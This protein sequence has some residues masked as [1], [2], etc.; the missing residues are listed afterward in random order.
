MKRSRVFRLVPAISLACMLLAFGYERADGNNT[1]VKVDNPGE[2]LGENRRRELDWLCREASNEAELYRKLGRHDDAIRLVEEYVE[3]LEKTDYERYPVLV[4]QLYSELASA[5]DAAAE[6]NIQ[7][8]GG[9]WES[10]SE[11]PV[12][13]EYMDRAIEWERKAVQLYERSGELI[14]ISGHL[15]MLAI[16]YQL[17]G[18]FGAAEETLKKDISYAENAP[19]D[20]FAMRTMP[21]YAKR[22]LMDLYIDQERIDEAREVEREMEMMIEERGITE[23]STQ[24]VR[25]MFEDM[26]ERMRRCR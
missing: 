5:Y 4:G 19:L 23:Y 16:Y 2:D 3:K 26:V 10:L 6:A 14:F 17:I 25:D 21:F 20:G 12:A 11:L 15:E 8:E 13:S 9:D 22:Y 18:D 24:D 1:D 7:R